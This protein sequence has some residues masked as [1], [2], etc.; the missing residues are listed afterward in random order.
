M[1][2]EKNAFFCCSVAALKS[3]SIFSLSVFLFRQFLLLNLLI[4]EII[5]YAA[6]ATKQHQ[7]SRQNIM[8][9]FT[10]FLFILLLAAFSC[11]FGC[12]LGAFNI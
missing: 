7:S 6:S 9:A 11:F 10:I 4:H 8:K 1:E 3:S 2:R 12:C 5:Y